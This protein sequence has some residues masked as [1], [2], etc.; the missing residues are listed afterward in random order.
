[1]VRCNVLQILFLQR[2]FAAPMYCR[3][4]R[5]CHRLLL[6]VASVLVGLGLTGCV[7]LP[8]ATATTSSREAAALLEASAAAHGW[9]AY[10][11]RHDI[12][13]RHEGRWFAAIVRIQPVLVDRAFREVADERILPGRQTS[14]K[15]YSGGSG[16][17][18][19]TFRAPGA[20][21]VWTN[22]QPE[23]AEVKRAAAA[24]VL[25]AYRLFWL[26]PIFLK[27]AGA[28]VELVGTGDF[29]GEPCDL[30]LARLRPGFGLA[31]E[32]RV[33]A[34]VSRRDRRFRRI[35][36]S[37]E[38]LESTRGAV[39]E[40]DYQNYR[41]FGG[42]HLPT[43]LMERVKRP[44]PVPVREWWLTGVDFDR[45]YA[46]ESLRGP[47]WPAAVAAPAQPLAK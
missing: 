11:E 4:R 14:A 1:M 38:G 35:R 17:V 5:P 23:P 32:D 9:S 25:D 13:L 12:N 46:A 34:W 7:N 36:H 39:V 28:V 6:S 43:R 42:L 16:G 19:L 31:T 2:R 8:P 29:D 3:L 26:G 40:V 22:G 20:V 30:L 41:D 24:L 27:E 18:K 37:V 15:F 45:G 33:L 44:V 21:E 10:A 47:Q